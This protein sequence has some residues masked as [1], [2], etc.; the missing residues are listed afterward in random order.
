MLATIYVINP[1]H[2]V[3]MTM[4]RNRGALSASLLLIGILAFMI[5][6]YCYYRS[7]CVWDP[8]SDYGNARLA[9]RYEQGGCLLSICF[10]VSIAAGTW[11]LASIKHRAI[12]YTYVCCVIV[13]SI[14]IWV[15]SAMYFGTLGLN[16][17]LSR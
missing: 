6:I 7:G 10:L 2:G 16:Q 13:A 1:F 12:A 4:S 11:L 5:A 17:L 3:A 8:K 9:D 15:I 14:T